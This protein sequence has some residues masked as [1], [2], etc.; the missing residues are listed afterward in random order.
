MLRGFGLFATAASPSSA[1]LRPSR[2]VVSGTTK[3]PRLAAA[4]A[5]RRGAPR[6]AWLER[7]LSA[8]A[9]PAKS[10]VRADPPSQVGRGRALA[11]AAAVP[12]RAA[13]GRP[14]ARWEA[15]V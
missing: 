4:P 14:R 10:P 7:E 1:P 2:A 15:A 5:H 12:S 6:A 11:R 13:S 3:S 8:E 9:R